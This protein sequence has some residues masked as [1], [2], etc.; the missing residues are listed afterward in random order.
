MKTEFDAITTIRLLGIVAAAPRSVEATSNVR[1]LGALGDGIHDDD[2]AINSAIAA[3]KA[4]GPGSIVHFPAGTYR[5]VSGAD[6]WAHIKIIGAHRHITVTGNTMTGCAMPGIL[7]T[8]AAELK[9]G[10]NTFENWTE[11]QRLP[12]HM[13]WV[14]MN[15]IQPVGKIHCNP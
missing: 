3:A 4:A 15:R 13:R 14:G 2:P 7:V 9:L 11:T 6:Q 12:G 8:S 10:E 1:E 5:L